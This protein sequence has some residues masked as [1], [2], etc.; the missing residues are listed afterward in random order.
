MFAYQYAWKILK[1]QL[2]LLLGRLAYIVEPFALFEP[3]WFSICPILKAIPP[4]TLTHLLNISFTV[5]AYPGYGYNHEYYCLYSPAFKF[6]EGLLLHT[7]QCATLP[8]A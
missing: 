4:K 6:S 2:W 1:T 3:A 5:K 7:T 8:M